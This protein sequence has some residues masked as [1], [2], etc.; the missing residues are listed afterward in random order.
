VI[1]DLVVALLWLVVTAYAVTGGAD[2][3]GGAWDLLAGGTRRGAAPRALITRAIGPIWESNHVWLVIVLVVLWTCFPPVFGALMTTLFVPLSAAAFGIILRGSGFAFR[4]ASRTLRYQRLTGAAF[5][6]SSVITPFF[7]GSAA[8]AVVTGQVPATGGDLIGSWTTPTSVAMGLLAVAAFAY[9][10]AVY[11]THEAAHHDRH[12]TAYFRR[13]ALGS[14][15]IVGGL[16]A[17]S[18]YEVFANAPREAHRLVGGQGLPLFA[19]SIVLGV[20][21][22]A[23]L[24][25][26][27]TPGLRYLAAG[28]F[29]ALLWAGA[30]AEYPVMLPGAYTV[31]QAAAP[32]STLVSE[33]V[34]VAVILAIVV[35]SFVVLYRLAQRGL[36]A[37]DAPGDAATGDGPS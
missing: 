26:G 27:R 15:V 8:G 30:L 9:L 36:L 12:L 24:V 11:L 7:F 32:S 28:A 37:E 18:L 34:V 14:G 33:L 17:W 29:S 35:P 1:A 2:F 10:A 4:Q 20:T 5:A 6:S 3:G 22:L 23:L 13:R 21:V 31:H 19:A 16:A 25:T